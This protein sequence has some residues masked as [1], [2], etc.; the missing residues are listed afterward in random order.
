[1]SNKSKLELRVGN[2]DCTNDAAV[3][4]RRLK[5]LPGVDD[6]RIWPKSAKVQLLYDADLIDEEAIR[7]HL[8]AAGFPPFAGS[9]LPVMPKPWRNRKVVFS[10]ISGIL[11]LVGFLLGF[12][13]VPDWLPNVFYVGAMLSGGFY[14]GREALQSLIYEREVG[15]EL[16]MSVA[17][18]VA[19]LMGQLG[20]AAMLVFLYS[21]S[22]A[23]EGYTEEKTRSAVRALMELAPVTA[24]VRRHGREV[25]IPAEQLQV[26]DVFIVK[27][28]EAIPTDG[29]ILLGTTTVDESPITGESMPAEKKVG[30]PVFAGSING[31]GAIEVK[32]TKTFAD[33]TIARIIQ[34]V[35][36]AQERKGKRQ[37]FVERFG[38]R[39]SPIVLVI[40]VFIALAPPLFFGGAWETWIS[41][42][43]VFI[44]AAAPCALVI[45]IPITSVATLGTGAR[46]GILIKGGIYVETLAKVKVVAFDKTGT[47][48]TGK[49]EVS[50]VL[51][52]TRDASPDDWLA[53]VAGIESRSE[54]PLA[55]A[56]LDYARKQHIQPVNIMDFQAL[57]GTGAKAQWQGREI[58]V[59][60]PALFES[61]GHRLDGISETIERLQ[62]EGNT[63]IMAGDEEGIFGVIAIRDTLRDNA[64]KVVNQLHQLGIHPVVMLTG[65]NERTA[66]AIAKEVGIDDVYADLLP[67][68]KVAIVQT[69]GR[70]YGEVAMVGDGVNDAPAL[71]E[72]AVGVAMGAAGTDAAL[73]A[74]DVALLADDLAKLVEAIHLARRSQRVVAEN[75]ALSALVIGVLVVGAIGGVFTLPMA[76]LGHEISEFIVIASGLRMLND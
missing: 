43:T 9:A 7:D 51:S 72:A 41:R 50:S 10:V 38:K 30:D 22:E 61:L 60:S 69:L 20:E 35:E 29:V 56:I 8:N 48:T 34:M 52:L 54:H 23:V 70:Q 28:G 74:A 13:S 45:S 36:D 67:E 44:V 3:L 62:E 26:G 68:D 11:L 39:Y 37:R 46:K 65:D 53:V 32:A 31:V 21:I 1:M 15:I 27:P 14:F 47:I 12:A 16:L 64:A 40:A 57:T 59:G 49:P 5:E 73:E 17:A 18:I 2:L 6:I 58:Y 71:A 33:N 75:I 76:V 24:L 25:E 19:A 42:A 4:Q 66:R 63:V 55:R